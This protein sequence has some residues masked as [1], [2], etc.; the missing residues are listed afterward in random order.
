MTEKE[1]TEEAPAAAAAEASPQEEPKWEVSNGTLSIAC[2]D[3]TA[4]PAGLGARFG[5]ETRV[6]DVSFNAL[7][8]L[9]NLE[10]F[11]RV[12][13]LVAD[14]NALASAQ[15]GLAALAGSLRVLSVNNNAID[16][17]DAFLDALEPLKELRIL[18]MLKNPVSPSMFFGGDSEDY[19]RFR[20]YVVHRLRRLE[21]LD[22]QPVTPKER[23]EAIRRGVLLKV[24]KPESQRVPAAGSGGD[25]GAFDAATAAAAAAG[26]AQQE[27][28]DDGVAGLSQQMAAP[29]KSGPVK[30][31]V[32]S[33]VYYG[34][35]SEGN[36]FILNE[37]L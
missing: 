34:K 23:A 36:R 10:G 20:L 32:C 16:D 15:P 30:F 4:V 33:Y 24:A 22:T 17:L 5:A 14:N 2:H 8:T 9:E 27:Q 31:G 35:Q 13:T 11:G 28:A 29:G 7:T 18:S 12:E 6:L 3:L 19:A 25:E 21:L 26:G 37:D 1:Q